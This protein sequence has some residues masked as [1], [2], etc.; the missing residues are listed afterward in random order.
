[1]EDL[2]VLLEA[3]HLSLVLVSVVRTIV[4]ALKDYIA[5]VALCVMK[6]LVS[7]SHWHTK[8]F[9]LGPSLK[10]TDIPFKLSGSHHLRGHLCAL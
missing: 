2:R 10:I 9:K 6:L 7:T 3:R 8:T 1:M 5:A 4:V